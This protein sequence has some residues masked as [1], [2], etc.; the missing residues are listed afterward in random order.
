VEYAQSLAEDLKAELHVLHIARDVSDVALKHGSTGVFE[1]STKGVEGEDWLNQVLG[2]T[3]VI[4]RLDT[5]EVGSNVA[6]KITHYA[7]S[8]AIQLI[9]MATHGRTGLAHFWLG[10]ITEEVIRS[11][12]CPVLVIR[13]TA[14]EMQKSQTL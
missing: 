4:R 2:N 11:A 12:S 6:E 7:Q 1:P 13:P 9:V 14:N 10:S 5:I 8:H 3:G